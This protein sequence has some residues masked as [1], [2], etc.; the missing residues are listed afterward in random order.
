MAMEEGVIVVVSLFCITCGL[1]GVVSR[2]G[3]RHRQSFVP[4]GIRTEIWWGMAVLTGAG[5]AAVYTLSGL[6]DFQT[7]RFAALGNN[8]MEV[9]LSPLLRPKAF[10]GELFQITKFYFVLSL[11]LP[12]GVMGV[13]AGRRWVLPALLPLGLLVVWDHLPASSLAFQYASTLLPLFWLA[14]MW[15]AMR[16]SQPEIAVSA[17]ATSLV[18]SLFVGQLPY[19]SDTLVDIESRTYGVEHRLSRGPKTELGR[20]LNETVDRIRQDGGAVLATGRIAAHL[21]GN[22]DVETVGQYFQRRDRLARLPD[23]RDNPML[24]YQWLI[25]DQGELLHQQADEIQLVLEEARAKDLS[26]SRAEQRFWYCTAGRNRREP[27]RWSER[28]G[29]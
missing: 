1:F 14:S 13:L 22:H 4:F 5:F 3:Q 8:A 21:V 24:G 16:S 9:V 6:A 25:V 26:W 23:R 11:V 15:G 10:W 7:G 19:S 28:T 27:G 20:W 29:L 12:C 18:L 2:M 17:L